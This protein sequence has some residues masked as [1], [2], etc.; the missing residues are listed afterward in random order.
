MK[1]DAIGDYVLFRNFLSVIRREVPADTCIDLVGNYIWRDLAEELDAQFIEKFVWVDK[2]RFS[3]QP[4][5]RLTK[6]REI[7]QLHYEMVLHPT[8]SRDIVAEAIVKAARS[9]TKIGSNGHVQNLLPWQKKRYDKSYSKLISFVEEDQFEFLNYAR[10]FEVVI[11]ANPRISKPTIEL[12]TGPI[13]GN[14]TYK[15]YAI[16]FVGAS[17]PS[18]RWNVSGFAQVAGHLSSQYA[19]SILLCGGQGEREIADGIILRNKSGFLVNL[20]G[21]TTLSELTR[22]ISEA[23]LVVSNE[24]GAVHISAALE[25]PVV[26]I[27]NGSHFM[28]F[29]PYPKEL[30]RQYAVVYPYEMTDLIRRGGS[31]ISSQFRYGSDLDINS[32]DAQ[33]VILSIDRLLA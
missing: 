26:C 16:L 28:R 12:T 23:R 8:Y 5:Y 7:G 25:T 9:N 18:R 24:T 21:R 13:K 6:L 11:G 27:S 33:S 1:M 17:E 14:Q 32:V 15:P 2:R 20:A 3:T 10:F 4:L 31:Q 30:F 29:H 19:L 22:L